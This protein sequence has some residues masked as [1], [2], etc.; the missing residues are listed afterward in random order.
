MIKNV[1]IYCRVSTE[2]QKKYGISIDDQKDSLTKY[3]IANKYKIYDY[4]MDEGVSAGTISK[5][6]EF[7]R[8][9]NDLDNIDLIIFTRLDRFS[10]NVRDANNMLITLDEHNTAFR[11]IDDDDIDVSTADGRFIFNLKVNLA[12]RERNIDSERIRRANKYKYN[13]TKT[14]CTGMVSFGYKIDKDKKIVIKKTEAKI[15]KELFDYFI[16]THN[17]YKTIEWYQKRYGYKCEKTIKRYLRNSN[18]IGKHITWKNEIIEDYY[19]AI[20]DEDT[21]NKAQGI[22]DKNIK[23]YAHPSQYKKTPYIFTGMVKCKD[24]NHRMTSKTTGKDYHYYICRYYRL[25]KCTNNKVIIEKKI[26]EYLLNNI[27]EALKNKMLEL[28]NINQ[29]K[30]QKDNTNELKAKMNKL[31]ELYIEDMINYDYYKEEYNKLKEQIEIEKEKNKPKKVSKESIERIKKLLQQDIEI[32]YNKLNNDEKRQLWSSIIDY[33]EI[34]DKDH[35]NI[36]LY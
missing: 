36:V 9:I 30:P 34:E 19:P 2:E 14:A 10:R 7:L 3:C 26:E 27:K 15:V 24:C 6:K 8:M 20:I 23:N 17:L 18:Y 22:F 31:S 28:T 33:I 16:K 32:I 1:A 25:K 21:F 35:M 5:R 11:A 13:V 29:V 12:E 4:Y